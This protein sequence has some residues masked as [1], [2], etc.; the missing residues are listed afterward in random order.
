MPTPKKY[1]PSLEKGHQH[2]GKESLYS[3]LFQYESTFISLYL[4]IMVLP[5]IGD[6][7]MLPV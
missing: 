2:A 6:P 4:D 1:E 3:Y 7:W 5:P